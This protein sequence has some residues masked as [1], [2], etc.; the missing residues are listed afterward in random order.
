MF[1]DTLI[2]CIKWPAVK[3]DAISKEI[4]KKNSMIIHG[5][6]FQDKIQEEFRTQSQKKIQKESL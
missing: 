5:E 3:A 6:N 4:L 1:K 2:E